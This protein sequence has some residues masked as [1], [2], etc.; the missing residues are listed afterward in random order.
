VR[1]L[2]GGIALP[3]LTW[4]GPAGASPLEDP[5]AGGAVFSGPTQAHASSIFLNPAAL[6]FASRGLHLHVGG[7][8]R[9]DSIGIDRR[10]VDPGTGQLSDGGSV[11]S[12]TWSPGGTIAIYGSVLQ[13]QAVLGAAVHTT[14]FDRFPA[15]QDPLGYHVMGG[16]LYQ[17]LL[18]FAGCFRPADWFMFGL[19]VSIGYAGLD[20][21][22]Q[23][24]TALEAGGDPMR[25]IASDCG[26][27]P[28]GFENPEATEIYRLH[29]STGGLGGLF[30]KENIAV[31]LG[32]AFRVRA[33]W[34]LT[35]SVASP[36]G[37]IPARDYAL[38][39]S[40]TADVR[41]APRDGGE[42]HSGSAEITYRMPYLVWLG[43]RGPIL[44]GYDLVTGVRWQNLSRHD[45]FDIRL[46][47]GDLAGASVPEWYPRYRGLRDVWQGTV[48][49][50]G[51]EVGR[52]R[53]GGRLRVETGATT[54]RTVSPL[55]IDGL[56][57]GAAGGVE[58]RVSQHVVL[59]LGY[60]LSWFPEVTSDQSAFDPIA[61]LDCVD[62][63]YDFDRCGAARDGRAVPTAA[64]TYRRLRHAMSFSL[65][66]DSL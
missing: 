59:Q 25:G 65:R 50:E 45:L 49:L 66:Y 34:W 57:V 22:L 18:S 27:A 1:A 15:R 9:L 36:P 30:A 31:S 64:G 11:S 32:V 10:L 39:L 7:S 40:G 12:T 19:G 54:D 24:D 8:L 3:L 48:G 47:G 56:D 6:G 26:G 14:T 28:C 63:G 2:V 51:Q 38:V 16:H 60:D 21:D 53:F 52:T 35:L 55:Q 23:R 62:S 20:L 43:M 41:S 5:T 33:G 61:R 44:P 37:A 17:G 29:T 58:L 42:L 4:I 13:D 46:Y